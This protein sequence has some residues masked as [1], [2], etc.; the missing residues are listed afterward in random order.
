MFWRILKKDLKRK[1]SMNVILL[2]FIMLASM[3]VASGLNNVISVLN[4]TEYYFDQA[5]I[6]DYVIITM[7][8]NVMGTLDPVLQNDSVVDSYTMENVVYG[9]QTNLSDADGKEVITKNSVIFQSVEHVGIKYFDENNKEITSIPDGHAYVSGAFMKKN[10][11]K[12]GDKIKLSHSGLEMEI[13]LDGKAKDALLGSDFMGNTRFILNDKL[14]RKLLENEEIVKKYQGQIA[15]VQSDDVEGLISALSGVK[16]VGFRRSTL[17]MCYVMEMI[18]A[19]IVMI[20]S[21]CLILVSFVV[22]KFS[23]SFTISEEFRE[24]GVMKA[25]GITNGKIRSLYIIKYMMLAIA[26]AILGLGISF[27]FGTFLLKSVSENMLLGNSIGYLINIVGVILVVAIILLFSYGCTR[28]VKKMS[29]I[30]AVRSGQTGERYKKKFVHHIGRHGGNTSFALAFNDVITNPKRFMTIII[31]FCLCTLFTMI[32]AN[33]A[34]TMKSDAL[35]DT[36]GIKSDIYYTDIDG[37]MQMMGGEVSRVTEWLEHMEQNL[38]GIGIPGKAMVEV[39]YKYGVEFE[40]K[41]SS[42]TFQQG[43]GAHIADYKFQKGTA[44]KNRNEIAVTPVIARQLGAE[45]GDQLVIDFG[46]EKLTCVI[47]AEF[48]TM[49]NLGEIIR[50]HEDAPTSMN[51][52]TSVLPLQYIY[53]DE[54]TKEEIQ[55]RKERIKEFYDTEDVSDAREYCEDCVGVADTM[56]SV[57]YSLLGVTLIVVLLV[58]ILMERTF[59]TEEKTQIAILKAIGFKDRQIIMWH[60]YRFAMVSLVSVILA[61]ILSIPM[62]HLCINP[63]FG[64]MG[65]RNISYRINALEI[66]AIIPAVIFT[67]TILFAGFSA[68]HTKEITSSDT[69]NIE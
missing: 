39:Q 31:S 33:T 44:P 14:Y 12:P 4:G 7:G 57:K 32:T 62:T 65:A 48:E 1:K 63:V 2:L 5:G 52:A 27:P 50:L 16:N 22:L 30:D 67:G 41:T 38:T 59:V 13:I 49:N 68:L 53:T 37:S 8:E 26:G 23:I 10:H 46:T 55:D 36:F 45:I 24:I 51:Y 18:L 47:T 60:V 43:V 17:K 69:A 3:F 9:A 66:F 19:F 56:E 58:T 29:P 11:M 20:L 64:M 15:Y 34:S 28:K 25:I 35:I 40:G 42:I 54:P 6:D 61:G 21:I